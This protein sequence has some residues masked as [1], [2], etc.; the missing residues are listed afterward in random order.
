MVARFPASPRAGVSLLMG[1]FGRSD[2][3]RRL[4]FT[5][6]LSLMH[7]LLSGQLDEYLTSSAGAPPPV[8][9]T[10]PRSRR[11]PHQLDASPEAAFNSFT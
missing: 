10:F 9:K 11:G 4:Y 7:P 2:F 5:M 3:G 6:A 8:F 1:S